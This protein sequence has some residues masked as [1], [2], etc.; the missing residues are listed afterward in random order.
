MSAWFIKICIFESKIKNQAQ[1]SLCNFKKNCIRLLCKMLSIL[2][3]SIM[4]PYMRSF[5]ICVL[6]LLSLLLNTFAAISATII[7]LNMLWY[8]N[9][10]LPLTW[11]EIK[12]NIMSTVI[13]TRPIVIFF[14]QSL[15]V[16]LCFGLQK[17]QKLAIY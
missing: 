10:N 8:K 15:K 7:A 12:T 3:H 11:Y 5:L 13:F 14:F 9:T 16:Q 2:F 6:F 4:C 1:R 17:T